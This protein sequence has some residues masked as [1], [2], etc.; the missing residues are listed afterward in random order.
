[1]ENED[2]NEE[3]ALRHKIRWA[4][5]RVARMRQFAKDLEVPPPPDFPADGLPL[6]GELQSLAMRIA[7]I[8]EEY[9]FNLERPHVG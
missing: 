8:T 2:E 5:F 6:L 4:E 1:M 7:D 9:K 3:A